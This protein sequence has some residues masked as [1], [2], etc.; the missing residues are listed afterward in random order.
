MIL[1]EIDTAR[2][3]S[4]TGTK[5]VGQRYRVGDNEVD[6]L[7]L[8]ITRDANATVV[9][10]KVLAVLRV[11]VDNAGDV[12]SR[13]ALI[14]AVWG[15]QYGGEERLSRAISLLRKALGDVRGQH[16]HIE[17]LPKVGYRLS[18]N[19]QQIADSGSD[20]LGTKKLRIP[21]RFAITAALMLVMIGLMIRVFDS[22]N[23]PATP[24]L[25]QRRHQGV[26]KAPSAN[27]VAVLPFADLSADGDQQYFS[28]GL[29]EEILDALAMIQGLSVAGRTSSFGY[30]NSDED[31][32]SIGKALGVNF[33]LQGSVRKQG[34][35]A[36]VSA[37][38]LRVTDGYQLWSKT[39]DGD[40]NDIFE[41]QETIARAIAE[42]LS[43]STSVV[44]PARFAPA[45]TQDREAYELFLQ[46]REMSRRFGRPAKLAAI[47]LLSQAVQRDPSFADA[48][49]WLARSH[50]FI[51][52][53]NPD[54]EFGDHISS[55]RVAVQRALDKNP[56]LAMAHYVSALLYDYDLRF[57][58]SFDAIERAYAA[59]PNQPYFAIRR[60]FYHI[61]LGYVA[62]GAQMIEAGLRRD[63]T[64][65]VGLLNLGT[66][67]LHLGDVAGGMM[68]I[69]RS[70][71][72]GFAP[73]SLIACIYGGVLDRLSASLDC[74]EELPPTI[75]SRYPTA[76]TE[77]SIWQD[78]GRSMVLGDPAAASRIGELA[79]LLA[80]DYSVPMSTYLLGALQ[81]TGG[82]GITMRTFIERPF[83]L[84]AS[85]M[86]SVWLG[87]WIGP[88]IPRH[89]EFP[90]FAERVGL[91][92]A[93]AR[94]GWPDYCR[95]KSPAL[96]A[97]SNTVKPGNFYCE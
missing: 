69:Q 67:K 31:I 59:A 11:L 65:A 46:G 7:W 62:A 76:L 38:L 22:P 15:S 26:S 3:A 42:E 84:N 78:L 33:L 23:E 79:A 50:L 49:A 91:T 83:L 87:D 93:W 4:A 64:D 53:T 90:A 21:L 75:R 8:R 40:L 13:E 25:T 37:Q 96:K 95:P 43:P 2:A 32:A 56:Q 44:R 47:A 61:A 12:V 60:G 6:F 89:P 74:W 35:Q 16:Q 97:E 20:A 28:D 70:A 29:A 80:D 66:A 41:F 45:L 88:R 81:S 24:D 48:W 73:A 9:E 51:P 36:R 72:L 19:V 17:T 68:A 77:E 71:A 92:R 57:D 63:P 5:A 18:A 58:A 52:I 86:R 55:A 27:A 1:S 34:E 14:D 39:F 94:H 10:P 85:S 54:G 30:R 82:A